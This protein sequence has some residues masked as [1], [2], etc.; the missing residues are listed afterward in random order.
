MS[1]MKCLIPQ[2]VKCTVDVLSGLFLN[3]GYLTLLVSMNSQAAIK[4]EV[5]AVIAQAAHEAETQCF[6]KIHHDT[7]EYDTCL[8]QM[9]SHEKQATARRLGIE[10]FGF[11]GAMNSYRMSMLGSENSAWYFLKKFRLT[12]K[13]LGI[14]DQTLC[15]SIPGNCVV[16]I[17]QMKQLE[18][19][20]APKPIDPH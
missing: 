14:D 7:F 19:S 15:Q 4:P 8:K 2:C 1:G 10:Y 11:V 20:P 13:R 17:A 9:L 12:Q 18:R 5:R 6:R 3:I 16:R